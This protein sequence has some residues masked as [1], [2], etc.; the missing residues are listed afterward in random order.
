MAGTL[1]PDPRALE[2][3]QERLVD[4]FVFMCMLVGNDFLPGMPHLDVADGALNTMLRTYTDL[5][6][7][8]GYLTDK[9]T[10]HLGTFERYVA[11]I[12]DI[13]PA[14]FDRK[15][16]RAAGGGRGGGRGRSSRRPQ[17]AAQAVV[18][19][20]P[21]DYK[22]EYYLNKFGMHPKDA[23]RRRA[24]VHSYVEGLCW[25]LA[26][27]HD[28]CASWDWYF[29]D[30]YAP[31]AT[32][33]LAL[34]ELD[35]SL[36]LGTP[37]PPLAQL[38]AVLP[39]QSSQ[40]V[41]PPYRE[42]MLSVTSPVYDAYPADFALDLNGKRAEWEAIALLPFIDERR[43]LSALAAIDD[44]LTPAEVQRNINTVDTYYNPP[45]REDYRPAA[46]AP[47]AA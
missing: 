10:L 32:D 14:V 12:S 33:L 9:A 16:R 13:E 5:L 24:I 30:F 31:L 21:R 29:P 15:A 40:L 3:D 47:T 20:D 18:L 43:L 8:N 35:I 26:Y 25:C 46:L 42:L 6:P 34:D 39:P 38:L 2:Y 28:G 19:T 1:R 44:Q 41:P 45:G 27:Y 37:F 7:T 23:E 22:R 17:G 36:D 11:A 4:D